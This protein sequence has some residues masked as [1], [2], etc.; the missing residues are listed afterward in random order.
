[1]KELYVCLWNEEQKCHHIEPLKN[2]LEDCVNMVMQG[3]PQKW[4]LVFIGNLSNSCKFGRKLY[5]ERGLKE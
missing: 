1:M 3:K 5:K 2:Y 4:V